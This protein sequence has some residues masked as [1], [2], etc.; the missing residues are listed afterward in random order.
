MAVR[1][2]LVSY[3]WF[4][5][6]ILEGLEA[7][8]AATVWTLT[9]RAAQIAR[10]NHPY[11]DHRADGLTSTI[12]AHDPHMRGDHIYAIWGAHSPALYI[13][14]GTAHNDPFP[15]LRPAADRAYKLLPFAGGGIAGALHGSGQMH[16]ARTPPKF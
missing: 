3:Q 6:R 8:T 14:F 2:T 9:K 4:G 10:E 1:G 13:E 12:F 7:E 5:G 16:L 11:Q 15:F